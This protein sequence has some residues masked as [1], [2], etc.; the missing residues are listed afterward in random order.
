MKLSGM[1]RPSI[2]LEESVKP[3]QHIKTA[4]QFTEVTEKLPI[5]SPTKDP[6]DSKVLFK[7][8]P[9]LKL[10]TT[11]FGNKHLSFHHTIKWNT[12]GLMVN[13]IAKTKFSGTN[14]PKKMLDN[15]MVLTQHINMA[16]QFT[17]EMANQFSP[18][19]T[20]DQQDINQVLVDD[21]CKN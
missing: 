1:K 10:N 3:N 8:T 17:V 9:K 12:P 13:S 5:P 4:Y 21:Q 7:R 14:K 6:Q 16:N 11:T 19:P 15:P 18:I 2:K 20:K